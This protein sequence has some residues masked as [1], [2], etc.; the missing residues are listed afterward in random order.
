MPP[1][2]LYMLIKTFLSD[3]KVP[4]EEGPDDG[5]GSDG[6]GADVGAGVGAIN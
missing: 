6:V 5:V 1:A 4:G 3:A 2:L